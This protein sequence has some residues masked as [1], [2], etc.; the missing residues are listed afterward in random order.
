MIWVFSYVS[1]DYHAVERVQ[2]KYCC[3]LRLIFVYVVNY[4]SL[5]TAKK[6]CNDNNNIMIE[7][8]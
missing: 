8:I 2:R 3:N 1:I 7:N 5:N 6:I 4:L